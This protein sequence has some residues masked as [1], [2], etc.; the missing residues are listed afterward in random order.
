MRGAATAIGFI[1][2]PIALTGASVVAGSTPFVD[3]MARFAG[4]V[5]QGTF[6]EGW[7]LP[8]EYLW[9]A[10]HGLLLLWAAGAF[11]LVWQMV[12]HRD[13]VTRRAIAWIGAAAA[14]YLILVIGS[15]GLGKFVV[16][17]RL[18]REMVPFFCLTAAAAVAGV[19]ARWHL[20]RVAA[21]AAILVAFQVALNFWQP[22]V[23]QF[24]LQV[25]EA[26][27]SSY[28]PVGR[29]LT[30]KGPPISGS[31]PSVASRYVLLNAQ[32]LYPIQA[33]KKAPAGRVL[34]QTPHPLQYLPY[35]FEGYDPVERSV[36]QS[37]D[38]SIRLIQVQ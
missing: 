18:A 4:T 27:A 34:L 28:G 12:A 36:L 38:L 37:V 11:V 30:V 29:A 20:N 23:Q 31:D 6:S 25:Q 26:V 32:Y 8:W 19:S 5:D 24:P 35:Q 1:V 16:Y 13:Q 17:G 14:V 3:L 22:I 2:V 33:P 15:A 9:D 21:Y 7:R 10:E